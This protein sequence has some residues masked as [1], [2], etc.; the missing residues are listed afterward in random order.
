MRL[1]QAVRLAMDGGER[2]LE[3]VTAA[4]MLRIKA[5]EDEIFMWQLRLQEIIMLADKVMNVAHGWLSM[6]VRAKK[7]GQFWFELYSNGTLMFF[8]DP[9]VAVLG[10]V[11]HK[12]R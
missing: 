12:V 1:A 11:C 8:S 9:D 2:V 10:Q 4:K 7:F 3:I 6:E 5:S